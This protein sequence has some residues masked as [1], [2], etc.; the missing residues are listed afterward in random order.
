M[1]YSRQSG[2]LLAKLFRSPLA[3]LR[4]AR[5]V[6]R[7][8]PIF[9][10]KGPKIPELTFGKDG[11]MLLVGHNSAGFYYKV[12]FAFLL[13]W[14]L[15][16]YFQKKSNPT[17][18]FSNKHATNAYVYLIGAGLIA[19]ML[20]S[21]RHLRYLYLH[22]NGTQCTVVMH[23][24]F[25]LWYSEAVVEISTFKGVRHM[26]KPSMGVYRLNY[27]IDGWFRT[28]ET[29]LIFRPEFV[30]DRDIWKLVRT[31]NHIYTPE[32]AEKNRL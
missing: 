26:F 2:A 16:S 5:R 28:R 4:L 3:N 15:V 9:R 27:K 22:K 25:S 10:K 8:G 14:Y 18:I 23:K 17:Y 30:H 31:G 24:F 20:M 32:Y 13:G 19:T 6:N 29:Y 11:K 12:N 21:N 1:K 7:T